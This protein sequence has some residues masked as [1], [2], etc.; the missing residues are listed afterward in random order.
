[1]TEIVQEAA[2]AVILPI[3]GVFDSFGLMQGSNAPL[4]RFIVVGG[5]AGLAVW[6]TRPSFAFQGGEPRPWTMM[7]GPNVARE[8]AQPTATPWW[9]P[10]LVAGVVF[11]FLI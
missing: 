11:S 5:L 4:R 10:S 7:V 2:S 6:A 1:M 3:E 8:G 9:V